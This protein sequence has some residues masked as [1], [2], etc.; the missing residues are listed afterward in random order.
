MLQSVSPLLYRTQTF[1]CIYTS[2]LCMFLPSICMCNLPQ[3]SSAAWAA[4]LWLLSVYIG[5]LIRFFCSLE[6]CFY[7][8]FESL[9]C[10]HRSVIRLHTS[11][12]HTWL[13]GD[14]NQYTKTVADKQNF[15]HTPTNGF[16]LKL[17]VWCLWES[18]EERERE[19]NFHFGPTMKKQKHA[20]RK[21][22][23]RNERA[24]EEKEWIFTSIG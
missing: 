2:Y 5:F 24:S 8:A 19:R 16:L 3:P 4:V 23:E 9:S 22:R 20:I 1:I 12:Q 11:K 15:I 10:G 6:I 7:I 21:L 17:F 18:N 14:R 13:H